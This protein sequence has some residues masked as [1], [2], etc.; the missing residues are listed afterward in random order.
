MTSQ[1]ACMQEIMVRRTAY[2]YFTLPLP[3]QL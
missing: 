1:A 2:P 3:L